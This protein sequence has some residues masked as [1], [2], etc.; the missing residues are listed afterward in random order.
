MVSP[1]R[2]LLASNL[3]ACLGRFVEVDGGGRV[4]DVEIEDVGVSVVVHVVEGRGP[5]GHGHGSDLRRECS[6][7][8]PALPFVVYDDLQPP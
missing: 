3:R 6:D 1:T 2:R 4:T 7:D 5:D 8:L